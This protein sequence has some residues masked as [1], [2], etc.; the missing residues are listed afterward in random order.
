MTIEW[1]ARYTHQ[2][3]HTHKHEMES[4]WAD[5]RRSRNSQSRS[6]IESGERVGQADTVVGTCVRVALPCQSTRARCRCER[7]HADAL[8]WSPSV[9]AE[10]ATGAW[11][12]IP[13][14]CR[15]RHDGSQQSVR[16]DWRGESP[17][18]AACAE[19]SA[20]M[21]ARAQSAVLAVGGLA[22]RARR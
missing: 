22:R 5:R 12:A 2:T 15:A 20:T 3:M 13:G 1:C 17:A 4:R 19:E 21:R 7:R 18:L 6:K 16:M 11:R 9:G 14:L 10:R 8:S